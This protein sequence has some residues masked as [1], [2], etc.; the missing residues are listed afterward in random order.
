MK[1]IKYCALTTL[2][3]SLK[4]FVLPS[5]DNLREHGYEVTVSCAEDESFRKET[6]G[7]YPYFALNIARGFHL[8]KTVQ[9]TISLYRFFRKEHFDMIEY[10][11]ENVALCAAVAGFFAGVPVRI[12]NHWG[13]RYVGLS[14]V[15][16]FLS[17]WI[18]RLAALF[19][20][21]VRQV[22]NRNAEMC[23][24]QHLYPA[25]KVKVLGKGGTIGVDLTRFDCGKKQQYR[26]E[27]FAQYGLLP[28][29]F[30][31]GY[32]GRI[33]TDKGINELIQA[34]KALREDSE[35][36]LLLVGNVDEQNPIRQDY[37]D[38]ARS[39]DHVIFTGQVN[40]A[41]RYMSAMDVLVHPTYREGFGMVLQEAAAVM[42]P[43]ITTDIMGPGEFIQNG[44][45]GILVEPRNAEQLCEAMRCLLSDPDLRNQFAQKDYEYV[46]QHFERSVMLAGILKDRENLAKKVK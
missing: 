43:I 29:A 30:V 19:S 16:R 8:S 21:D 26:N 22:S 13:A 11:T 2:A 20:T 39:N 6:E 23:V 28:D 3:T 27:V 4:S 24:R 32:V 46:C 7:R 34:F 9:S 42:T 25:E 41:Y 38:W 17:I 15:S 10:G 1:K 35:A 18:E 14:G 31:F 45:T 33:Q 44:E 36:Y 5:L 12:Y 40:D 37:M